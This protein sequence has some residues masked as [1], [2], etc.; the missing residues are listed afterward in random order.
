[1]IETA[2]RAPKSITQIAENVTIITAEDISR[3]HAHS[4]DDILNRV[5]GLFT[6]STPHIPRIQTRATVRL[7]RGNFVSCFFTKTIN[8]P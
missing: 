1:L 4:I 7:V 6:F 8:L 5:S 2:T 3:M